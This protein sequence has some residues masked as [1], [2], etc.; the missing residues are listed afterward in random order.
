MTATATTTAA[1]AHEWLPEN[2]YRLRRCKHCGAHPFEDAL[3]RLR[4][5]AHV[6]VGDGSGQQQPHRSCYGSYETCGE[7]HAHDETCGSRTLICGRPE[8]QDAVALLEWIEARL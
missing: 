4:Y 1:C 7:H 5:R 8:D 2:R 6:H 3:A